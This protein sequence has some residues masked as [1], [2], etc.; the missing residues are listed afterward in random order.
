MR[1]RTQNSLVSEE[2]LINKIRGGHGILRRYRS[3]RVGL[4]AP[5]VIPRR[6][7]SPMGRHCRTVPPEYVH[8]CLTLDPRQVPRY[9]PPERDDQ[10]VIRRYKHGRCCQRQSCRPTE[11][12]PSLIRCG[13]HDKEEGEYSKVD[14]SRTCDVGTRPDPPDERYGE[15]MSTGFAVRVQSVPRRDR[16][17][18]H[19]DGADLEGSRHDDE[20]GVCVEVERSGRINTTPKCM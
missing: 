5:Q 20:I 10:R 17:E 3:V 13:D 16:V 19:Q 18:R 7:A 8:P 14:T 2:K 12:V 15:E 9:V 6:R 1:P 11:A 4:T